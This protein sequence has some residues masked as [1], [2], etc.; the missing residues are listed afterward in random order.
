[1]SWALVFSGQGMQHPGMLAWLQQDELLAELDTRLGAD[2]RA[3][4]AEPDDAGNNR[5]AQLL[6]TT[7]ACA[8]WAQLQPLLLARLGPPALIAGYSVGELAAFAAAGVFDA[9][10]AIE[11]AGRRADCMDAAAAA[12]PATGLLGLSGAPAGAVAEL[13]A[14]FDLDV[15]IRI[16]LGSAVLGGPQPALHAAADAAAAQGWRCT[17]L[18]VALASHTRW[19][20]AAAESFGRVLAQVD[21]QPP[22][23]PLFSN[24]LGRVRHAAQART[25]LASQI[26]TTVRWD[27][28]LDAI[29]AQ[30]VR[31][32]LE[33]GPGQAL[34]RMWRDRHPDVPARSADEFRS[35]QAVAAWLV[36]QVDDA[37]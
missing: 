14:R 11:L 27:D 15:A 18:N 2:W 1:M 31:A 25:A 22:A 8:A 24:A 37:G 28:C 34:A 10:S 9:T 19:M 29:A 3:R 5:R 26:A 12:A 17:P 21:L 35:A 30:R 36:R 13:C 32:V 6:L 33:I 20:Q 7:T 4:L 16:D 23:L